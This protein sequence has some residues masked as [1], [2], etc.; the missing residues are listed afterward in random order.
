MITRFRQVLE[1]LRVEWRNSTQRFALPEGR[2]ENIKYLIPP[3]RSRTYNR[4]DRH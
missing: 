1:V 4:R 3:G 2:N